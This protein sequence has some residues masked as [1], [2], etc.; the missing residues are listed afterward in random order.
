MPN[1]DGYGLARRLRQEP[2]LNH[3]VLIALTGYGQDRDKQRTAEAGFDR[4]LVKPIGMDT[5]RHLLASIP[6]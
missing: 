3:T 2:Q 4:H 5:L 1:M 6:E